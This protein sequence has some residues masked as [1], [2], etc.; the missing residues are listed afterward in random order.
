MSRAYKNIDKSV[1]LKI[2]IETIPNSS[3]QKL[4][5][6]FF[7]N[8]LDFDEHVT[9]LCRKVSQKLN[10]LARVVL[11][12]SLAQRRLVMNLYTNTCYLDF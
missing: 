10:A 6:I 1:A 4:L 11:Y 3:N 8:K 2:K 5:G 9:S 7:N 12:M